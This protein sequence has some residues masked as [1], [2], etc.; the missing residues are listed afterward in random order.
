MVIYHPPMN[1]NGGQRK[2]N[3]NIQHAGVYASRRFFTRGKDTV[4]VPSEASRSQRAMI[5]PEEVADMG[6]ER[7]VDGSRVI[8]GAPLLDSRS[9]GFSYRLGVGVSL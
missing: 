2:H 4:P 8:V 3:Q 6:T 1:H 5:N 9:K 7:E